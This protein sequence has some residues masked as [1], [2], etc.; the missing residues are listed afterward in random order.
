[1]NLI[2]SSVGRWTPLAVTCS[3]YTWSHCIINKQYTWCAVA[4]HCLNHSSE[5]NVRSKPTG[6]YLCLSLAIR[7]EVD[8]IHMC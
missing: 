6:G 5:T 2:T 4:K 7:L 1:M 8:E 3:E